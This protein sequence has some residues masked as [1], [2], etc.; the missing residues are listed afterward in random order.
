[1]I[2]YSVLPDE[3]VF[4]D[5]EDYTPQY[6]DIEVGGLR[7]QVEAISGHKARIVRLYSTNPQDYLNP[8]YAPG[9]EIDFHPQFGTFT[10]NR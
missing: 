8:S 3:I 7:M 6:T 4:K 1:M 9:T 10:Q 2:V 5:M